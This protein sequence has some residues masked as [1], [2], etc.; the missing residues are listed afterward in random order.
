MK[1]LV[2]LLFSKALKVKRGKA[3]ITINCSDYIGWSIFTT[4]SYEPKTLA[5]AERLMS[6][7][8]TFVDIGANFGLYT[9]CLGVLPG[10]ECFAIEPAARAF[11]ALQDNIYLNPS[12]HTHLYNVALGSSFELVEI[13]D[14]D[15]GNM[16]KIRILLNDKY[17]SS[18]CHTAD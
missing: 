18:R 13:E 11:T 15:S 4:G 7:G 8:G 2:E 12:I 1:S 14:F 16:G 17:E 9:C 10:V 3:T 5:L 6:G